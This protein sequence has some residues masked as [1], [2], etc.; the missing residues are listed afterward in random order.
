[1]K[2][3]FAQKGRPLTSTDT[4]L[5][6]FYADLVGE[7]KTYSEATLESLNHLVDRMESSGKSNAETIHGNVVRLY[8]YDS[9]QQAEAAME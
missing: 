3:S 1:M 2:K 4:D 6:P 9:I 5:T 8:G 7:L